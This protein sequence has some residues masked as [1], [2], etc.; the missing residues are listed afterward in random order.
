MSMVI[1]LSA[2]ISI[3]KHLMCQG[4]CLDFRLQEI[5]ISFKS[6]EKVVLNIIYTSTV[7]T[8]QLI[9]NGVEVEDNNDTQNCYAQV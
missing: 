6:Q 1:W 7:T 5:L 2:N 3:Y 4:A 9:K 8:H